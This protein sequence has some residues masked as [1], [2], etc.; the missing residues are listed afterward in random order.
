MLILVY[1][2]FSISS[3]KPTKIYFGQNTSNNYPIIASRNNK[4]D[5]DGFKRAWVFG[6]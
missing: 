6:Y 1:A 3:A 2:I 4:G 5:K